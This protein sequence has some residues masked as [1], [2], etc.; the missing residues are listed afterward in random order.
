M[1]VVYCLDENYKELAYYSIRSVRK[2]NPNAEIITVSE[3]DIGLRIDG[4][5]NIYI[6]LPDKELRRRNSKD[7][8]TRA[9]YLKCFLTKLP[10]EK[11]IYLDGDTIC[12]APLNELWE[13][14]CEYINLCESHKFGKNQAEDLHLKKYGLTGM[15]VMNLE[16]LRKFNFT[17]KCLDVEHNFPTPATGWFH[18]ETCINVALKDKLKFIDTKWNYCH[19]RE[20]DKPIPE[21]QA[22]ILHYVGR[23]S[24]CEMKLLPDY[25]P[26]EPIKNDI[27]GKRVAIVGNAKSLFNYSKGVEID[28]FD[29]VIR[30][31]RGYITRPECQGSKTNLLLLACELTN[32]EIRSYNSVWVANRSNCYRNPVYFTIPNQDRQLIRN[33]LE[34]QPSTGFMAIDLCL[35]SGAKS[36]DLFGFDFE[37]TPTFYNPEGYKT[38]HNYSLEEKI[39]LD[40]ER[41]GLLTINPKTE[42]KKDDKRNQI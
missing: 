38:Q 33:K 8:I 19:N 9:A 35:A 15:M 40:Y 21:P 13:M 26:L 4:V 2:F 14:P 34:C 25:N 42:Q 10:F 31:N 29:F 17:E 3:K 41:C 30:F 39:V 7:R 5:K 12:Q 36:I 6:P 27:K 16:N 1:I 24:K 37:K 22:K 20:Y 32:E 11:I 18:D 28:T 23:R